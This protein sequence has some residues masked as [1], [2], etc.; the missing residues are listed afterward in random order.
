M[1]LFALGIYFL[2]WHSWRQALRLTDELNVERHQSLT[3]SLLKVHYLALPLMIPTWIIYLVVLQWRAP[4]VTS[5]DAAILTLGVFA[6]VTLPHHLLAERMN[7]SR[8]TGNGPRTLIQS[9]HDK[10][11]HLQNAMDATWT[12]NLLPRTQQRGESIARS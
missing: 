6:V 8:I 5:V 3:R 11:R 4:A 9:S 12:A 7:A 2:C 10:A 1:N